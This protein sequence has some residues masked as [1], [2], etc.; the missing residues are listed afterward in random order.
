MFAVGDD[1]VESAGNAGE[2][3]GAGVGDDGDVKLERAVRHRSRVL[4]N[5]T[6]FEAVE[7]SA[8]TFD[9]DVASGTLYVSAGG[10]HLT[11]GSAF[12]IAVDLFFEKHSAEVGVGGFVVGGLWSDF[13]VEGAGG[14]VGHGFL[15]SG[16]GGLRI[17]E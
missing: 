10:E 9:C 8:D 16:C 5:K 2:L 1:D 13:Y 17:R 11:G 12:E 4:K 14:V 6:S 7:G 15:L 3:I